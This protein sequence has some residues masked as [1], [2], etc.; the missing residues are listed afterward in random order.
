MTTPTM[1]MVTFNAVAGTL[2]GVSGTLASSGDLSTY[3]FTRSGSGSV[4]NVPA[5][6]VF[7]PTIGSQRRANGTII[8]AGKND[9]TSG[10][11]LA[12]VAEVITA[13]VDYLSPGTRYVV[14][15]HFADNYMVPGNGNRTRMNTENSRLAATYGSLY[16]DVNSYLSSPQVWIDSGVTPTATDAT[17]QANGVI[18]TSLR[19]NGGHLNGAGYTAVAKMVG[20]IIEAQGWF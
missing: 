6:S 2:V 9:I 14:L 12:V 3:V 5:N 4:V 7:T 16:V 13:M 8:W 17:D 11:S 19:Y 18:P 1:N 15:G 20:D 10:G